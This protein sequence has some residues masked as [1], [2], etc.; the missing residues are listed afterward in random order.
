M[1][2]RSENILQNSISNQSQYCVSY[3][4]VAS[5]EC[6]K[7]EKK[8]KKDLTAFSLLPFI[9]WET[10]STKLS[11]SSK[12]ALRLHP[13]KSRNYHPNL[14]SFYSLSVITVFWQGLLS[15]TYTQTQKELSAQSC[16][17]DMDH[18]PLKFIQFSLF[19]SV[20]ADVT[21]FLTHI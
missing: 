11:V 15:Q 6:K 14:A 7:K 1:A 5:T 3:L 12:Y 17:F 19:S 8:K 20:W 21:N 9:F 4:H 2:N 16:I 18:F 10:Y 13:Q